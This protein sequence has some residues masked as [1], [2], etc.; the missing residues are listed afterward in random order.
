MSQPRAITA[1]QRFGVYWA[2]DGRCFWCRKPVKFADC[3]V[4]HVIPV[5]ATDPIETLRH[6]YSL[7]PTFEIDGFENWAP[8]CQACNLMKRSM[9]LSASPATVMLLQA[10]QERAPKAKSIADD[11][12]RDRQVAPLLAKLQNA[13]E[14]GKISQVEIETIISKAPLPSETVRISEEWEVQQ[15]EGKARVVLSPLYT[16]EGRRQFRAEQ[17]TIKQRIN[18]L[19]SQSAQLDALKA[20]FD[21]TT[22]QGEDQLNQLSEEKTEIARELARLKP[23]LANGGLGFTGHLDQRQPTPGQG[24]MPSETHPRRYRLLVPSAKWISHVEKFPC[25]W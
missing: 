6:H 2:W 25:P 18:Q 21:P 5:S 9:L 16:T 1:V 3:H 8:S 10:V 13:M 23:L 11:L 24:V 14:R 7:S 19:S 22:A 15:T 12:D 20:N 4:D 17:A